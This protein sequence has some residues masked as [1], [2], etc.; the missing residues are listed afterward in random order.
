M[1]K[2]ALGRGLGALLPADEKA[3][4]Q[5]EEVVKEKY[6]LDDSG[7]KS[8]L[9]E[10]DI[11]LIDP[12]PFQPRIEFDEDALNEL[13]Q[14]IVEHGL[15]Q[16][17]SV[18]QKA[19]NRYELIAGERRLRASKLAQVKLVPVYVLDIKTD[20]EM[21]ELAIIEN[22][23]R[24]QLNA[25]EI[26]L[27]YKRLIDECKL[28]QEQV[29]HRVAKD[30]TTVTNFL[31]LLKLPDYV[32]KAVSS[33]HLSM[34]HARALISVEDQHFLKTIFQKI[35]N[36]G[37]NVREVERL[38]KAGPE[39]LQKKNKKN[40]TALQDVHPS[41]AEVEERLRNVLSTKVK[42]KEKSKGQ[43]EIII[44]YYTDDELER[45]LDL[46]ESIGNV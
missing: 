17:L 21:L 16:P 15:I 23:H 36:D 42:I 46:I 1:A 20:Q 33:D 35:I 4:K 7:L 18:R 8:K 31:R 39:Y 29:S 25:I 13:K 44:D 14:S 43:G 24:E 2:L 37:L 5:V 41:V 10:V 3:E 26:A 38:V 45:L 30:R 22:I 9:Q 34:G 6:N 32:Q 28:T 27:G 40:S 19:N 12:N 11:N